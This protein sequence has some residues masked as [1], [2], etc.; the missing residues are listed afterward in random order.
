MRRR[1]TSSG[2]GWRSGP[3]AGAARR[4]CRA[5]RARRRRRPRSRSARAAVDSRC[6]TTTTVRPSVSALERALDGVLGARVEVRRRLVEHEHRRVGERGAGERHQLPLTGRQP[7]P[8]LAHLG[9]EPLGERRRTARGARAPRARRRPRR[10]S[11][12]P[13]RRGRCRGSC[14][15]NRKPSCGTTTMRS[16]SDASVAVAQVDAAEATPCLARVVEA[17]DELGQ[18]RLARAGRADEREPLARRDVQRSRRAARRRSA[19]RERHVV[20]VDRA[21]ARA[22]RPRPGFSAI[23]GGVSRSPNSLFSAAPA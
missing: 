9:V 1:R 15:A 2:T 3:R 18:R 23:D 5:R 4:G 19:V 22:G 12:R 7:R 21:V 14:P 16:R 13:A 8:A 10:R 11:R 17:G 20:D 6:A